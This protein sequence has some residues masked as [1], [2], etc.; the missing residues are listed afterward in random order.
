MKR[1]EMVLAVLA[2]VVALT[3]SANASFAD[4]SSI[5]DPMKRLACYDKAANAAAPPAKPAAV[6]PIWDTASNAK[7]AQ[8][9]AKAPSGTSVPRSW[10]EADIGF[11]AS[12]RNVPGKTPYAP[13]FSGPNFVPTSPGFIGLFSISTVTNPHETPVNF[14]GGVNYAWGYWLNPQQTTAIQGSAFFGLGYANSHSAQADTA[15][16]I[17]TTPDVFVQLFDDNTK[18]AAGGIWDVF[19][20]TDVNYRMRVPHSQYFPYFPDDTKFDVLVGWRY[21]GLDELT[22]SSS[23]IFTRTYRTE[24][25]LPPP[26]NAQLV[27]SSRPKFLSVWN[28]FIGPQTGFNVEQHWGRYWVESENKVAVGATIEPVWTGPTTLSTTP[29]QS[30]FL[31]GIPLQVNNG[32]SSITG[33]GHSTF[34]IKAAFTVVPNGTLKIGY[35]IIPDRRSVTLAYN[36]L[37]MSQ[38]GLIGYQFPSPGSPSIRQSSF[39]AQG[40]T[41]GYKEKF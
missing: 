13:P 9:I 39:F 29:T 23:S 11:Y 5:A 27:N 41:F 35:D 25:G 38:V 28:N 3:S 40:I 37:Y 14:G 20:G 18:V 19:Y 6:N 34:N 30:I 4:C 2:G 16:F 17:N 22:F 26:F 7:P 36:Y 33:T 15:T 24:L 12:F 21:I 1:I 8:A 32:D 31:A 10:V